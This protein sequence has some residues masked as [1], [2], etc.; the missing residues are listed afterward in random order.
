LFPVKDNIRTDRV[1]FIT[2]LFM[3]LNVAAYVWERNPGNGLLW[4]GP[5]AGFIDQ[6]DAMPYSLFLNPALLPLA[7]NMMFLWLF[8]NSLEDAMGKIRYACFYVLGGLISIA[9][10]YAIGGEP[11]ALVGSTGASAAILGGYLVHY[12]HGKVLTVVPVPFFV[13]VV[14]VVAI[15]FLG[16]WIA[17]QILF[18]ALGLTTSPGGDELAAYLAPIAGLLF[19]AVSVKL[20]AV[21]SSPSYAIAPE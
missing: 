13:T 18:A 3:A 21:R 4:D 12:P 9:A 5:S 7:A 2:V 20:F 19:G 1:A 14:E 16:V 6:H 17:L 15:A 10:A 8:G 11:V